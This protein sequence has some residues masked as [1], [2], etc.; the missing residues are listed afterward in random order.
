M[1]RRIAGLFT[2]V[3]VLTSGKAMADT[4]LAYGKRV[5][6]S[7]S[8]LGAGANAVDGNLYTKWSVSGSTSWLYVDLGAST[9]VSRWVVKHDAAGSDQLDYYDTRN[10]QLQY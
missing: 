8:N 7:G 3:A 2:L 1:P 6:V 10:F 4:N 9:Q 5:V